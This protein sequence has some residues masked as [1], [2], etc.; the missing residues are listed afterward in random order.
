[1]G[2]QKKGYTS[3]EIGVAWLKDWDKQT[4]AKAGG[5]ARLL[6]V[7]GHSSHYTLGFLEY[8]RDNN[9]VVLCYPSHST[10]VYQGLD[11]VVFSVLKRTWSDERDR[12]EALG[13]AVT[14]LNF[15]TVYAKA[16]ARTFTESNIR[17]AFAKTGIVPYNPGVITTEMMAPSLETSTTSLLP[18]GLA[19]PVHEVVDLISH[20]NARKRKHQE[21]EGVKPE[22]AVAGGL[23]P[24]TPVQCGL[25]SLAM[26]SASF[27]VSASLIQSDMVLPPLFTTTITPPTQQDAMLLDVKPSNEFEAQLQAALHTSNMVVAMQK[28]VM[29]GMQA[30]TVLQSMYLEGVQG[31]L[32]AQ[33]EKKIKKR[34]TGKINMDGWAKILTQDNIIE[35]MKEWQDGQDKAVE[36]AT[37]KKKAKEQYNLAM[38]VWKVR[39]MD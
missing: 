20:H 21:T 22:Q 38:D 5:Q 28:Q 15:M 34:K 10:H 35:G 2:Y 26:T 27:L 33:E 12:F 3:G 32:Q 4:K 17:A 23:L 14:K 18:L 9:V 11:V 7:D 31:Q 19:T 1:M 16:H 29:A 24:Y 13:H 6:L 8:A 36:E 39:E 30:Q 25:A 37:S